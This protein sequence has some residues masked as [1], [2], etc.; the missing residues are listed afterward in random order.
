MKQMINAEVR[1]R[2]LED[3]VKLGH[4]GIREVEF[5]AQCFQLIRGG[6][7]RGLQQRELLAVLRE[8]AVLGYL[9]AAMAEELTS[10]YLFLRD[11]EHAIQGYQDRQSQKLPTDD[12]HR[13]A[14]WAERRYLSDGTRL[15]QPKGIP[16]ERTGSY[17]LY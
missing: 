17:G 10:A 12:R 4:G 6:R 3:D 7:D 15:D 14:L 13:E 16:S 8:C 9:P 1:R 2:G 5:I 11:S